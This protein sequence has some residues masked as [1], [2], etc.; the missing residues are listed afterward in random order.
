MMI[1]LGSLIYSFNTISVYQQ[2]S[3]RS[4]S[5]ASAVMRDIESLTLPANAVLQIYTFSGVTYTSSSTV[6]VLEIPSI[7]NSGNVIANT[8]DYAVF[9]SVDTNVYRLIEANAL[10][11]RSSSVKKLSSTVNTLSFVYD[12]DMDFTQ[13]SIVT[14]DI[15]TQTEAK[16]EIISDHMSEQ[17][18]LRNH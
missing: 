12:N 7:D 2:A 18:R 17:I 1:A 3:M 9:Y 5:S 15:Q 13:I 16:Q 8:Y 4:S 10:S 11:N 14:V 6:L